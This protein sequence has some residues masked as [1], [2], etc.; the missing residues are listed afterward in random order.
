MSRRRARV[1]VPFPIAV[2]LYLAGSD[3]MEERLRWARGLGHTVR[4]GGKAFWVVTPSI[5]VS[6]VVRV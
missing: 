6:V 2:T 3:S 4:Y 1:L 5:G